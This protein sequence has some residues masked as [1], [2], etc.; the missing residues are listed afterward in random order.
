LHKRNKVGDITMLDFK[1]YL[2]VRVTKTAWYYYKTRFVDQGKRIV[3]P[4]IN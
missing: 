1:P 4:E 3:I 2:R